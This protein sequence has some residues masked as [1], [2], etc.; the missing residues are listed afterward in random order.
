MNGST[1]TLGII[2]ALAA[3]G[4]GKVSRRRGS[5]SISRQAIPSTYWELAG[6]VG[7]FYEV[8]SD[9]GLRAPDDSDDDFYDTDF[10]MDMLI[11]MLRSRGYDV[12]GQG[13]SRV[14]VDVG[15]GFVAKVAA[16]EGGI[17]QNVAESNLWSALSE[18]GYE[19]LA[20]VLMPAHRLDEDGVVLLT[21]LAIPCTDR[22]MS[23]SDLDECEEAKGR[24]R[25]VLR[26]HSMTW[27][28][29]DADYLFNWGFHE[30]RIKLLDYGS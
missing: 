27:G 6:D 30:G 12:V 22:H 29:S 15:D 1:L 2:G 18:E 16:H 5:S 11:G 20:E 13:G 23:D 9:T 19:D 24:G 7:R 17:E 3:A 4:A 26:R 10:L 25:E 28:I 21:E 8:L 14:A